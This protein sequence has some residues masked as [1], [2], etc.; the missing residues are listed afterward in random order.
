M[1]AGLPPP[2]NAFPLVSA[3]LFQLP[4]GCNLLNVTEFIT[5]KG[6]NPTHSAALVY[7]TGDTKY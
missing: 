5:N 1:S 2:P 4:G 3:G 6:I 7:C